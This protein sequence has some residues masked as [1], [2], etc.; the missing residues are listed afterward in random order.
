MWP[1]LDLRLALATLRFENARGTAGRSP[2][3]VAIEWCV[4][5]GIHLRKVPLS[6]FIFETQESAQLWLRPGPGRSFMAVASGTWQ[7]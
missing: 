2:R 5:C 3:R 6:E 4:T 7:Q 1:S